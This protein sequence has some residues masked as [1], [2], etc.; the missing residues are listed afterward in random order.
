M[1]IE[2]ITIYIKIYK[3]NLYSKRITKITDLDIG[4][5]NFDAQYLPDNKRIV[6]MN[7][8][9]SGGA[10]RIAILNLLTNI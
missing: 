9:E 3:I 4:V 5:Q 8:M 7:Q 10:I 2:Y 1:F 6:M